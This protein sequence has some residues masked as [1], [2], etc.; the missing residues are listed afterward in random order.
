[1]LA[2]L[3]LVNHQTYVIAQSNSQKKLPVPKQIESPIGQAPNKTSR[4]G[5][6]D[7][8]AKAMLASLKK[9]KG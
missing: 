1:M 2:L 4:R 6:A 9:L 7:Q 3:N 8:Q 5:D